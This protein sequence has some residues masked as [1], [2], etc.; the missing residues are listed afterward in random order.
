M[1]ERLT[2]EPVHEDDEALA[3]A[4]REGSHLAFA[5]LYRRFR[6][7]VAG[8][9]RP[10]LGAGADDAIQNVFLAIHQGLA[11]YRGPRFFPWAYRICVNVVTDELRRRGRRG[12]E[13]SVWSDAASRRNGPTPEEEVVARRL[14]ARL[15]GAL[16][17]LPEGQ[18]MVFVLARVEGLGYAEIADLLS[19]PEGTVKSRMWQAVRALLGPEEARS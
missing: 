17:R 8:Y 1:A 14:F 9:V 11:G 10:R 15:S 6:P 2:R 7:I 13:M 18:R 4:A 16:E 19:I 3:L 12:L 5:E